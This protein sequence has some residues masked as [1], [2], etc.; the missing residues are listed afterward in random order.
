METPDNITIEG[1]HTLDWYTSSTH[2]VTIM[3]INGMVLY[4]MNTH[5]TH[6]AIFQMLI[7]NVTNANG[8]MDEAISGLEATDVKVLNPDPSILTMSEDDLIAIYKNFIQRYSR[9]EVAPKNICSGRFWKVNDG[10]ISF[11]DEQKKVMNFIGYVEQLI[12]HLDFDP[13]TVRWEVQ[14]RNGKHKLVSYSEYTIYQKRPKESKA[15]EE[16]RAQQ[17][18][19]HTKAGMKRLMGVQVPPR[20]TKDVEFKQMRQESLSK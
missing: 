14:T 9:P 5:L 8:N 18:A 6:I 11:W 12:K 7:K 2:P 20:A 19:L 17:Y 13:Q 4:S 15:D 3:I 1:G 16:A 10:Y